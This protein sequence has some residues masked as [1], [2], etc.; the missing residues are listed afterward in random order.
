[1]GTRASHNPSSALRQELGKPNH[2]LHVAWKVIRPSHVEH[3]AQYACQPYKLRLG[4]YRLKPRPRVED[5]AG[6]KEAGPKTPQSANKG[7]GHNSGV[8]H[9]P[10]TPILFEKYRDTPP[11]SIA[12]LLQKYALRLAESNII[13][14]TNLYHDTPPIGIAI[15]FQ[16]Y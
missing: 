11:I 5:I 10:L 9:R 14:T 1:M 6:G 13:Y 15:L 2:V 4:L 16:K 12:I 3:E 7:K 8:S